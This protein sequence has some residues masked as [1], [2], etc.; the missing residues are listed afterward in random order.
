MIYIIALHST[1]QAVL[2]TVQFPSTMKIPNRLRIPSKAYCVS[3]L[4]QTL[5]AVALDPSSPLALVVGGAKG[6]LTME[7]ESTCFVTYLANG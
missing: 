7:R 6:G 1:H 2:F 4:M 3:C 5:E